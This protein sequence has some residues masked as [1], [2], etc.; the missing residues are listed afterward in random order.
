M[1]KHPNQY[2]KNG[3]VCF[4]A[5]SDF[6]TLNEALKEEYTNLIEQGHHEELHTGLYSW[7]N[8][9]DR[10]VIEFLPPAEEGKWK[11]LEWKGYLFVYGLSMKHYLEFWSK[12][13]RTFEVIFHNFR[14]FDGQFILRAMEDNGYFRIDKDEKLQLLKE[15]GLDT[16]ATNAK[17]VKKALKNLL[18]REYTLFNDEG[19][20]IYEIKMRNKLNSKDNSIVIFGGNE[21]M[22]QGS[23]K[24]F[25]ESLADTAVANGW[26]R[27]KANDWFHK[28]GLAN[29][30]G[31]AYL[32]TQKY[33]SIE[34]LEQDGNELHYMLQ[35]C[36]IIKE[37]RKRCQDII[38]RDK[39]K[40]TI[41]STAQGDW[42]TR[43]VESMIKKG[44]ATGAI[45]KK[46]VKARDD[47]KSEFYI[48][49]INKSFYTIKASRKAW[50]EYQLT[51]MIYST[52]FPLE[53]SED[54]V[55]GRNGEETTIHHDIID[56]WYNGG[57]TLVNPKYQNRVMRRKARVLDITSS[58]P[59]VMKQ[60]KVPFGSA[61]EGD[62]SGAD[63]KL[64]TITILR[65]ITNE[66][67]MPF[68]YVKSSRAEAKDWVKTLKVGDVLYLTS[69][70]YQRFI[71][72]YQP[73]ERD[74]NKVVNYSFYT[75]DG[76]VIFGD[77]IDYW[78]SVKEEATKLGDEVMRY[79][80][81]LFL[82]SLYGKF[83]MDSVRETRDW[84]EEHKEWL[85]IE[86][87]IT[88]I[89]Q[90]IPMA[91]SITADARM[92]LVDAVGLW[93]SLFVYSD[94]DSV[95]WLTDQDGNCVNFNGEVPEGQW[96][97]G[98]FKPLVDG[99]VNLG[100]W[101]PETEYP[102]THFVARRTKQY[103][104]WFENKTKFR[105]AGLN[106]TDED[107][108]NLSPLEMLEG[109]A[110]N[111]DKNLRP[112]NTKEGRL[113][114]PITKKITPAWN[115]NF[116]RKQ[117]QVYYTQTEIMNKYHQDVL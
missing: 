17:E 92:K 113:L 98:K 30:Q 56:K 70:E 112:V 48:Y 78:F 6:E 105:Y 54:S 58:Y 103:G 104:I 43:F 97:N 25:G 66:K 82:N 95:L 55:Y 39:W 117:D 108:A 84:D 61:F 81:K 47:K 69:I 109:K 21:W 57:I 14:A 41:A 3:K 2:R 26:E 9:F 46:L 44:M 114:V 34:E 65:E 85:P 33:N 28:K 22:F 52:F 38:Q 64:L 16:K 76:E 80:A 106:L 49:F 59:S 1:I 91:V 35:D 19:G 101:E 8:C 75:I 99:I 62:V 72:Y 40:M 67:G 90:Y 18:H 13:K 29:A 89:Q 45:T 102:S 79:I 93:Y 87:E 7:G 96:V 15:H 107:I 4:E 51:Q 11:Y 110:I 83:G 100:K 31:K 50:K 24:S 36:F 23:V 27:E 115:K 63:F 42:K 74:F 86:T 32:R 12:C 68:L 116:K 88:K 73:R 77:Y 5:T 71:T 94:T 60:R 20:K 37:F 53:W 111:N 10:D